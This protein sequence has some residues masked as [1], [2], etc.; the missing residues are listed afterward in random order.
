V[1]DLQWIAVTKRGTARRIA[2]SAVAAATLAG[3]GSEPSREVPVACTEPGYFE[4][5]REISRCFVAGADA[6]DVQA[7]GYALLPAVRR[8]REPERLGYLVGAV[9]K[10]VAGGKVYAELL[11]RVEQELAARDTASPAFRRG[12]RAGRARG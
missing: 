7:I 11:R 2:T 1:E 8:E 6:G 3:C 12:E 9:R 10:G 5:A 4:R